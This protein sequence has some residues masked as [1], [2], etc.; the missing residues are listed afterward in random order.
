MGVGA[1]ITVLALTAL[2]SPV[3]AVIIAAVLGGLSVFFGL[4]A[5]YDHMTRTK[6]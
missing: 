3:L 1:A 5:L 2:V 6:R 4:F